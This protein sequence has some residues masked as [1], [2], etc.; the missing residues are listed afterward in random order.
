V[1]SILS[2]LPTS[3]QTFLMSATLGDDVQLL[4]KQALNRPAL[5]RMEEGAE[6]GEELLHQLSLRAETG[7][8]S[9][10][11]CCFGFWNFNCVF[12]FQR[13]TNFSLSMSC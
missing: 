8:K 4:Q 3:R 6:E 11:G 7:K 13:V 5:V 12:C 1:E 9:L 2:S 10:V